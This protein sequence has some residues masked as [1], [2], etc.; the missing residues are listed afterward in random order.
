MGVA[1]DTVPT[2]DPAFRFKV[3]IIATHQ[4]FKCN[5]VSPEAMTR[6]LAPIVL[7]QSNHRFKAEYIQNMLNVSCRIRTV[8]IGRR[9]IREKS[10]L[11]ILA[12]LIPLSLSHQTRSK[13]L[14]NDKNPKAF[15]LYAAVAG[16]ISNI[17][18]CKTMG[19]LAI[20]AY[21]LVALC[22]ETAHWIKSSRD[23]PEWYEA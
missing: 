2:A 6:L 12:F 19:I 20:Q 18:C 9:Y 13:Y 10:V 1:R 21:S 22:S 15:R 3:M 7:Y 17:G 23:T 14:N 4:L 5:R 8:Q 16:C 11:F